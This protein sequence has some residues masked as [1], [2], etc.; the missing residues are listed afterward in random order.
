MTAVLAVRDPEG[1]GVHD[2]RGLP[3]QP[4]MV[5]QGARLPGARE[6]D[7]AVLKTLPPE[8][9]AE[10]APFLERVPLQRRQILHERNVPISFAYFIE[11]GAAALL[12]R[13]PGSRETVEV[14]VFGRIDVIGAPVILGTMRSPHRCVVHIPGQALRIRSEDLQALM[15]DCAELR[16]VMLACVHVEMVQTAQ[17]VVCNARH[18]LRERLA[19]CLLVA[20]DRIGTNEIA[21]THNCISRGLGVRRAGVTTAMGEL[22]AQGIIRRGRAQIH[23]L[24]RA[25]LERVSCDCYRVIAAEQRRLLNGAGHTCRAKMTTPDV[26]APTVK[27]A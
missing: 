18:A 19:R 16:Q 25:Q 20:Q 14:G 17:L 8:L 24:D 13:S 27:L 26:R 10:I 9:L 7:N 11:R 4:E 1:R 3:L 6:V 12:T 21:L 23:V 2:L 5:R 22:E 15:E